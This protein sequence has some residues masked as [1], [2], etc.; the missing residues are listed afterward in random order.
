MGTSAMIGIYNEDGSV[1]ASYVHYDGYV[2]GVGRTLVNSYNTQYDAEIVSKGGYM[3]ALYNDYL[4]SREEA[5]HNDSATTYDS[6]QVFAKS[7]SRNTGAEYL[8]L[9]DGEAWFFMPTYEKGASFEEVEMN[10]KN[11]A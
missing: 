4:K 2:E 3:S 9:F 8:Y 5:V 6:V 7:A 10:L 11:A 1:T